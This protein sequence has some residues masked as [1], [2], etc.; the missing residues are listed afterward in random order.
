MHSHCA[1]P[2]RRLR[3]SLGALPALV[4]PKQGGCLLPLPSVTFQGTDIGI[5]M[6][7]LTGN[8]KSDITWQE[9]GLAHKHKST[10][11]L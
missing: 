4:Q 6:A 11:Y 8:V 3:H 1:M 5:S 2:L 9:Q 7:S 10:Q